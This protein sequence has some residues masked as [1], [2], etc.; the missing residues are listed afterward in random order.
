MRS[1]AIKT[2]SI[3]CAAVLVAACFCACNSDPNVKSDE[4]TTGS[5][6]SSDAYRVVESGNEQDEKEKEGFHA[7]GS[8]KT[9]PVKVNGTEV[10]PEDFALRS[11]ELS[12]MMGQTFSKPSEIPVD[13]AVQYAFVHLFF[14]DFHSINNKALEYRTATADEIKTELKKQFGTDDFAITDSVLYNAGKKLFEMWTPEYGTN[15][16]YTIDAVNVDG[17]TAEIITTFYNELKRSTMMGRTTITVK[18][19]DGKPVIAALKAE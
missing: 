19:Q 10:K 4:E 17:D 8:G 1:K 3:L 14:P 2:L 7:Y 15:I 13:A 5:S 11:Y 12:Q 16:Y 6:G 18:V 9:D